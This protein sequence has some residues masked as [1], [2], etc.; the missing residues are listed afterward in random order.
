[1]AIC[2]AMPSMS[3]PGRFKVE[4]L[5]ILDRFFRAT[6]VRSGQ[7][8][9]WPYDFSIIPIETISAIYE[10]FLKAASEEE[11]KAAGAF[12]TP[13]FLAE[14]V[15]D[16]SLEGV[17]SLLDKRFLD[18]ACGSGIFLV[19]LFNR[20]AEE[21]RRLHPDASYLQ[22][23]KGLLK[24]LRENI[25]GVDKNET[26]CRITAFSLYLAFLDQLL[27]PDIREL[28]RKGKVLPRLVY[29]PDE[30]KLK[31]AEGRSAARTSLPRKQNCQ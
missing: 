8:S 13:R 15:L 25:F 12:Y 23:V 20:M 31:S 29:A 1:M 5:E 16:V 18:P 2:S 7:Q 26:A 27:P 3:K 24:V 4:H 11:K 9:F 30:A 22:Q 21:W 10:H 17:P 14:L 6:D 19:G 28:Q